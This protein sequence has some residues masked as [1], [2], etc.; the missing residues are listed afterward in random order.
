MILTETALNVQINLRTRDILTILKF[1]IHQWFSTWV[2]LSPREH[3]AILEMFLVVTTRGERTVLHIG[4]RCCWI[5]YNAQDNLLQWSI[6]SQISQQCW[7]WDIFHKYRTYPYLFRFLLPQQWFSVYKPFFLHLFLKH[8][9]FS[10]A[11]VN[12]ILL[13]SLFGYLLLIHRN[14]IEFWIL[15]FESWDLAQ[16]VY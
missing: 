10:D 5:S 8:F 16:L 9:V 1:P 7:G 12:L 2:V 11:T 3:S 13:I 6:T 14:T 15:I 4:Q